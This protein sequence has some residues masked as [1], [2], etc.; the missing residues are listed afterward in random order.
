MNFK[1]WV[2]KLQSITW[3]LLTY[4]Q[5]IIVDTPYIDTS[6]YEL[7]MIVS[8]EYSLTSE[9]WMWRM[10]PG[11]NDHLWFALQPKVIWKKHEKLLLPVTWGMH[12]ELTCY[13]D[14]WSWRLMFYNRS[15]HPNIWDKLKKEPTVFLNY[16]V[17]I[18]D[19]KTILNSWVK[20]EICCSL[21]TFRKTF[22]CQP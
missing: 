3:G 16:M 6:W 11:R 17:H 19:L 1:G 20:S 21:L 10:K 8:S 12:G 9:S 5:R 2:G 14:L 15:G 7:W 18:F 22:H 4:S 13:N